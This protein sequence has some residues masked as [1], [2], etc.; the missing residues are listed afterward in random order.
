ML[1]IGKNEVKVFI[2][3]L[4]LIAGTTL[5]FIPPE[6]Y[7]NY[8]WNYLNETAPIYWIGQSFW[9]IIGAFLLALGYVVL[10]RILG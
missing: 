7:N 2:I 5:L 4:L 10:R 3:C 6:Q 9:L 1:N 8:F